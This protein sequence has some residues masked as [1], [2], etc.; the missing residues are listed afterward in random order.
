MCFF[1]FI[2]GFKMQELQLTLWC[3]KPICWTGIF[4]FLFEDDDTCLQNGRTRSIDGRNDRSQNM[5]LADNCICSWSVE[6]M[7]PEEKSFFFQLVWQAFDRLWGS[8][9]CLPLFC[10]GPTRFAPEYKVQLFWC[11]LLTLCC[12]LW[13]LIF[14]QLNG[15]PARPI[16]S[17][18][19]TWW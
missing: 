9:I 19:V 17:F 7:G 8:F 11:I 4:I 13:F 6:S 1:R 10:H 15:W 16:D 18:S 12:P 3:V 14:E 2:A 5:I